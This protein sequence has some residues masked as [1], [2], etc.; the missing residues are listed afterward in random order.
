MGVGV[1]VGVVVG[2]GVSSVCVPH[3]YTLQRTPKH[4]ATHIAAQMDLVGVSSVCVCVCVCVCSWVRLFM[5][6][7][8]HVCV[9]V[10][11]CV[12][13]CAFLS[14][15]C[16]CTHSHVSHESFCHFTHSCVTSL[17][18]MCTGKLKLQSGS[19]AF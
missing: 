17:I 5:C 16:G 15:V 8:V 18:R 4:T 11:V 12:C 1:G 10:R 3:C 2:V 6:A 7:C 14:C 19:E 13:V 9:C